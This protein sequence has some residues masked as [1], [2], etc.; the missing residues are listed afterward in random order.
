MILGKGTSLM[1]T[2]LLGP[3]SRTIPRVITWSQGRGAESY[4]RGTL[5]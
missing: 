5:V 2:L 1:K 4:E 3:S